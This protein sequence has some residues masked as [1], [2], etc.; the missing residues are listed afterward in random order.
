MNLPKGYLSWSQLNLWETSPQ[1]YI[2]QYI[3]GKSQ[4]ENKEM[5]FGKAFAEMLE[6]GGS[7]DPT[8]D[9][10]ARMLHKRK[11]QEAELNVELDGIKL[12]AIFDSSDKTGFDEYKTGKTP[13]SIQRVEM[14][15]QL[16]FYALT[17]KLEF[18]FIPEIALH[19]VPEIFAEYVNTTPCFSRRGLNCSVIWASER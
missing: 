7:P 5:R 3:Y 18:G 4:F 16:D 6:S 19:W 11:W 12:K 9:H 2:D 10:I 14:H 15:G 8:L 13:W 1:K 17:F